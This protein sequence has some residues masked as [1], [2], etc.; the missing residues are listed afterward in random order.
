MQGASTSP[1]QVIVVTGAAR[2]LGLAVAQ[3]FQSLGQRVWIASRSLAPGGGALAAQF[4]PRVVRS[5]LSEAQAA[6]DLARRVKELD[7]RVDHVV[8]AVGE[9]VRSP[10]RETSAA[11]L[12]R[13][14]ASNVFT[15]MHMAAAFRALL[16]QSQ[17][18]V[19]FFG[20]A[21]LH[22]PRAFQHTAAYA[23]AKS[24]LLVLT[25][26][27]ALEEAEFGV[28]VNMVSPGHIPHEHASSDTSDPDLW[29]QIPLGRPGRLDEVCD[30][31]EWLCSSRA[32]YVTGT[33]LE[34]GGGFNL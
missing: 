7:G 5:D 26:S 23:A 4:G 25:R 11:D 30:A 19:V 10:L 22:A 21:G 16:R 17:G 28:R 33:N 12:E 27:L 9:Y 2:G 14:F 29:R 6:E 3:R 20:S 34:L 31:V 24:A 18:S 15:S 1:S 32:S 13:M 8:H